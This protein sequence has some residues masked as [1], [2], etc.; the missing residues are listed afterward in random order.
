MSNFWGALH[1]RGDYPMIKIGIFWFIENQVYAV[2]QDVNLAYSSINH[3][4]DTDF[5]HWQ[6]WEDAA[7]KP[8]GI[9]LYQHEYFDFP[10]GRVLYNTTSFSS[11]VYL[12]KTLI[13]EATKN[14]ICQAF[15]LVSDKII[16]KTDDHYTT[17]KDLLAKMFDFD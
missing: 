9:K 7:I 2:C 1:L 14:K 10:R 3:I 8:R 17:D 6:V 13:N 15:N 11:L 12:D 16:W 4:L 5:E